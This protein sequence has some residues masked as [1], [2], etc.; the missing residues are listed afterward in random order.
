MRRERSSSAL[1]TGFV[2]PGVKF[3]VT[4]ILPCFHEWVAFLLFAGR[5][6]G[7]E[8]NRFAGG[9]PSLELNTAGPFPLPDAELA[10]RP[11]L[12]CSCVLAGFN[13]QC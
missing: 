12:R 2:P 4:E 9:V 3:A 7:S 13:A 6:K 1:L 11:I 5:V 10:R 8:P